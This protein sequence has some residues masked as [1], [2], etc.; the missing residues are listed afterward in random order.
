M[1]KISLLI[2]FLL[3]LTSCTLGMKM[4][5]LV[6]TP[7]HLTII[8]TVE[9]IDER[10]VD[11]LNSFAMKLYNELYETNKNVFISPASIYLALGMTYNGAEHNTA[12]E[13]GE[14]L[15]AK[16]MTLEKFNKLNHDLQ[17]LMLGYEKS[18]F[19]LANS[20]WI[21]DTYK[22]FV[23]ED[24][25]NQNMEYYGAMV[26]SLD[27]NNPKAKD[28]INRW[29]SKNTK[30][31]IKKGIDDEIHPLTVMFLINTIYFKANWEK[32]FEA[33]D[34]K[35]GNFYNLDNVNTVELMTKI[36]ILGYTENDL[37][38][39]V[40]LPYEDKKTSMFILCPKED[41]TNLSLSVQDIT[42][43]VQDMNDN[44]VS[45]NL[46]M[47]KVKLEYEV[48]LKEHLINLGMKDA[49]DGSA[50]FSK[51]ADN[52]VEEGLHIA[53]I[54]HKSFLAIDEKGTEAAAMT[55]V[56]MRLESAPMSDYVMIV[57]KPYLIGIIDNKSGALLFLGSIYNPSE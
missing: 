56:E 17:S 9:E 27:F 47:P 54:T 34:T 15:E 36:D 37:L 19:E 12:L 40:I 16:G 35:E 46:S 18:N 7:G 21:R 45:V 4:D 57:D 52:A 49:W 23:K 22:D 24:F 43:L 14:L 3:F 53:D 51:M 44:K 25:L 6:K 55:K 41:L 50:D 38:Q 13:M 2:T 48:G 20:I 11:N 42:V 30:G 33:H 29:V 26:S 8:N 1:K 10:I 28:T 31:R 5:E 32:T 39:G